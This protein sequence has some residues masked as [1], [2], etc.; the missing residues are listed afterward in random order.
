[1]LLIAFAAFVLLIAA[2]LM[3]PNGESAVAAKP[4]E[5]APVPSLTVS[6]AGA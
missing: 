1:M 5:A 6:E 3:A 4:V 2:W